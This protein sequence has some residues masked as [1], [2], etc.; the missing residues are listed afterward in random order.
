[1]AIL[2]LE[3]ASVVYASQSQPTRNKALNQAY[4]QYS[5]SD[6]YNEL[7]KHFSAPPVEYSLLQLTEFILQHHLL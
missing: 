5:A 2:I 7:M 6:I 3:Y 1:V 4:A